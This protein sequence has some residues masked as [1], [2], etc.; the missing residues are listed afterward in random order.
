M[1]T[2]EISIENFDDL[3][4]SYGLFNLSILDAQTNLKNM[5]C[6]EDFHQV[7]TK[8]MQIYAGLSVLAVLSFIGEANDFYHLEGC[9]NQ[10]L[11]DFFKIH[12]EILQTRLKEIAETNKSCH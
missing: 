7:L 6:K 11:S 12:K 3:I 1:Q 9:V 5:L 8:L 2:K 10:S 4:R